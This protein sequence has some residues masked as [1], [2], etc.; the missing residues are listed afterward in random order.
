MARLIDIRCT[1]CEYRNYDVWAE[2]GEYP[3][4]PTCGSPT[5]RLWTKTARVIGD[6][7]PGGVLI[8]HGLCNPDGSPRRYYSHT[9]MARE[10]KRR[11]LVN[12][13]RHIDGSPHTTRWI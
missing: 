12:V 8:E 10:A 9:E 5:E 13:V 7:I 2:A 1:S 3:A 4:C 11:G 6:D